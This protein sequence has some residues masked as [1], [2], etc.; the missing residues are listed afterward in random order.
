[1]SDYMAP[2][3]CQL[4]IV[5]HLDPRS[6]PFIHLF[7]EEHIEEN[8]EPNVIVTFALMSSSHLMS[9]TLNVE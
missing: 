5:P 3:Q 2:H 9:D 6:P 7:P 8:V 4:M 1:M